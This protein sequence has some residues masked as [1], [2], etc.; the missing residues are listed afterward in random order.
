LFCNFRY[1]HHCGDSGKNGDIHNIRHFR[2]GGDGEVQDFAIIAAMSKV[3][4]I[5]RISVFATYLNSSKS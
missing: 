2:Y 5:L 4:K 1:F 3:A